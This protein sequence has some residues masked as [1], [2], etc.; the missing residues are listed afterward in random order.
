MSRL[1]H[2]SAPEGVAPATAY[3]HV[4]MGTGRFVAISGQL[5]LDEDG[6]LVGEGDAAAQAHQVFENLRRCLT[7]AGAT[8]DDVVKLTYFVTDMAHMRAI[9]GARDAF[10]DPERLPASSAVQVGAL[11]AP[12]YLMEIE[13][14]AVVAE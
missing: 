1:T 3:T 8:F 14:F 4:V 7:A 2:I 12:E 10:L 6:K 11:V 9:R 13:A 5:A